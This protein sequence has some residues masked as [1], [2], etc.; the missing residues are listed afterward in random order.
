MRPRLRDDAD[1]DG[2]EY[3]PRDV[4]A[5]KCFN[6][7]VVQPDLN[8]EQRTESPE[9]NVQEML[10]DDVLP[11]VFL[12]DMLACRGNEPNHEQAD[13]CKNEV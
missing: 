7:K 11:K 9:E 3:H 1:Q 6:V 5:D 10:A 12:D 8:D 4:F 13:D 2:Q